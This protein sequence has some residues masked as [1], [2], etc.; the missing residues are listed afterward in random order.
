MH[1]L[2]LCNRSAAA[3]ML[4]LARQAHA[5]DANEWS[6]RMLAGAQRSGFEQEGQPLL[7]ARV[8]SLMTGPLPAG[9]AVRTVQQLARALEGVRASGASG[10]GAGNSAAVKASPPPMRSVAQVRVAYNNPEHWVVDV[11]GRF[12]PMA[13]QLQGDS[14]AAWTRTQAKFGP[15]L[16]VQLFDANVRGGT[17]AMLDLMDR[18]GSRHSL[19]VRDAAD[20]Q[21]TALSDGGRTP[22]VALVYE[23]TLHDAGHSAASYGVSALA[24]MYGDAHT[25]ELLRAVFQRQ[26]VVALDRTRSLLDQPQASR[27]LAQHIDRVFSGL[28]VNHLATVLQNTFVHGNDAALRLNHPWSQTPLDNA[29]RAEQILHANGLLAHLD[30]AGLRLVR[31]MV[32]GTDR[33]DTFEAAATR[34]AQSGDRAQFARDVQAWSAR[35]GRAVAQASATSAMSATQFKTNAVRSIAWGLMIERTAPGTLAQGPVNA[36]L[37]TAPTA[38]LNLN[39]RVHYLAVLREVQQALE[40]TK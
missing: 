21:Y 3:S 1:Q 16:S 6:A 31:A 22:H 15:A 36:E 32:H 35:V 5:P 17:L 4:T 9:Q 18:L 37:S 30:V 27:A 28:S 23:P 25:E 8:A 10:G 34:L 26:P 19:T 14:R 39:L 29:E 24:E 38:V 40:R 12:S 13:S 7:W 2:L 20:L 11:Q 33:A